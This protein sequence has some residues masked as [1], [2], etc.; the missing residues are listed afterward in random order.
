MLGVNWRPN[1]RRQLRQL[2]SYIADRDDHAATR[3]LTTIEEAVELAR[4]FPLAHRAGRS[5]GTREIVAHP[6]YI[7]VYRITATTLDVVS[8]VHARQKYP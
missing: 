2:I 4:S 6:N 3:L 5:P 8:V 7:V 1:A